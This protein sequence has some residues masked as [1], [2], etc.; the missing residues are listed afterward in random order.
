MEHKTTEV[1]KKRRP[2][3]TT[4]PK[5]KKVVSDFPISLYKETDMVAAELKM[6]RSSIIR[7]AMEELIKA[8][9]RRK[10][11]TDIA[12]YFNDRS[13]FE[14]E[15]MNDFKYVDSHT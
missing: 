4:T 9:H 14:R 15:V 12:E 5:T 1:H 13:D 7:R 11:R 10:L 6:S 8:R 3:A 2:V